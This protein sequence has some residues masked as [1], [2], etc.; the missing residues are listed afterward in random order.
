MSHMVDS[1]VVADASTRIIELLQDDDDGVFDDVLRVLLEALRSPLGFCGYID[2]NG[3]LVCASM[4][5][6]VF[7]AC[8][9]NG[10]SI[11]FPKSVWGG[12]WGQV[13][14]ERQ[15]KFKNAPHSVPPGH[16]AIQR[17]L[18]VPLLF[19]DELVGAIHVA[20]REYDYG[21]AD[22]LLLQ[23]IAR[24]IAPVLHSRLT[25]RRSVEHAA[26]DLAAQARRIAESEH[27]R[28]ELEQ[29]VAAARIAHAASEQSLRDLQSL[30]L[31]LLDATP[32]VIYVKR[33][34][35]EYLFINRLYE[36][37][38]Q[39]T[40]DGMVGRTDF[41]IFPPHVAQQFRD[42]DQLVARSAAPLQTQEI[43]R[44]PDGS[45]HVYL[46]VKFPLLNSQGE[47]YATAGISTDINDQIQ[48]EQQL[49]GLSRLRD[50]ILD[51]VGD[52]VFGIDAAGYA[53]FVNP[54]ATQLL[55]WTLDELRQ[56]PM[57]SLLGTPIA[58]LTVDAREGNR[59]IL[60]E[61]EQTSFRTKSGELIPVRF[62][63]RPL[64]PDGGGAVITFRDLRA[65]LQAP[66]DDGLRQAAERRQAETE[67]Q[68]RSVRRLQLE[69]FPGQDPL[70]PGYDIAG[71]NFPQQI[72]SGDFFDYIP[73]GDGS[74]VIV[75]G[76]SSG[77]DLSAAVHMVEAHAA[78][79]TM[80]DCG[81]PLGEMLQRLNVTLCR[82]LTGR[83][84]S[85]FVVRL[86]PATGLIEF[87]GAGHDAAI[88]RA[89]GRIEKL[90]STG[91]VLGLAKQALPAEFAEATL[92]PGDLALLLT[93]GVYEAANTHHKIFG[94]TRVINVVSAA[95]EL[96]SADII[97]RLRAEA[98]EF[99]RPLPPQD[100]MTAV[101]I[102]RLPAAGEVP[103][104]RDRA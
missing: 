43:V 44:H 69:L 85:L 57:H 16:L 73:H 78:L 68:L 11:R 102:R 53:T 3:D 93:D 86:Q 9:V 55:G 46:S 33:L 97:A 56:R 94:R 58:P 70:L 47:A 59:D 54:M 67:R 80:L 7:D 65:E 35:G 61:E 30:Y 20:N 96:R 25:H 62:V 34:N 36:Q 32:A 52:G 1:L 100:D 71:R 27:S 83:F 15:P 95:R 21:D 81:V 26:A 87:A 79:H 2:S 4:T 90:P 63:S 74:L 84:V 89:D 92:E 48:A 17:S 82:H 28:V 22:S 38:F 8:R 19:R 64:H 45:D 98:E 12:V 42:N 72:V 31:P 101:V 41:D 51:A 99:I 13:L 40:R 14:I 24:P 37:T 39:L 60:L 76:D 23:Q 75:L 18:G 10:K 88:V 6:G 104:E 5:G 66:L 103:D 49:A 91:L 77:H 50:L 29:S